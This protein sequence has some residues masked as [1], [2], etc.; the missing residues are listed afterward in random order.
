MILI[1]DGMMIL[2]VRWMAIAQLR[3]VELGADDSVCREFG[4]AVILELATEP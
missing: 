2:M 1:L 4:T 3:A